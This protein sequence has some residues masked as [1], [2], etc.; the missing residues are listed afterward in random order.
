MVL[1][2]TE[3]KTLPL[4]GS[5]GTI[6]VIGTDAV[7]ARLGGYSG[8]GVRPVSI[9]D[10]MRERAG[11][12]RVAYAP[13]PGRV[14]REHAVVPAA[15]LTTSVGGRVT[16]GLTGEYFD[17]NALGGE[18]RIVRTDERIDFG[19]TLNSPG[20]GI[21]FDWYSVRWRG[22]IT[23]PA[24]GATR[25]GVEG[26]DGYRLW[27]DGRLVIDNWRKQ[28]F[29]TRMADVALESG[30]AYD[31]RVEFFE[32][33]GN[34]RI[35]LV[36]D[37]GVRADWRAAIDSAAAIARS[38]DIAVVVA[39]IEEGEFRDRAFLSLPGH[40]EELIEAVAA[41]GRPVVV[42]LIGGSAIKMSRWIDDVDAVLMAWYPGIE[43]GHAL[44][45]V[46]FGDASPA[47]RLPI[48]FPMAEGQLPLVY[49][50]KPTGR[51]DDYLDLTGR[52]LFPFG[53]GLGYTDFT[54]DALTVSPDT[55]AAGDSVVI[56]FRVKNTGTRA[57]DA[58][59]QLYMRDVLASVARPISELRRF[60]RVRVEAGMETEIAFTL[61]AADFE[62]L[63]EAL[64]R[65]IE[66]GTF[67]IMIGESSRDIRLRREIAVGQRR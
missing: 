60:A 18:P 65:V 58:V 14:T 3:A 4:A 20:R 31:L 28:S 37:A 57:G 2:R 41:T 67:R 25:I 13:G 45:D 53:F 52:P 44:T 34:A 50:H 21:P 46:L 63:D 43:G 23:G 11:T 35:R 17:N 40:Q 62:M 5:T 66:D 8:A 16:P 9:L 24:G 7:E 27:L 15:S 19:W 26:T 36:W 55:I 51:G 48:T 10:A 61:M 38:S 32:T 12:R 49:N 54:Y 22:T 64:N 42:V 59:P 1:L 30:R 56:R 29:G 39:G 33:T 47:G 6:A